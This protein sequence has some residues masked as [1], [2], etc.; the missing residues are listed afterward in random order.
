MNVVLVLSSYLVSVQQQAHN[1]NKKGAF[2][3]LHQV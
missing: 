1:R 2:T 3:R